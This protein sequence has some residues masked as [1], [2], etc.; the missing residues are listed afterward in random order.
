LA[1]HEG[2]VGGVKTLIEER[3][4]SKYVLRKAVSALKDTVDTVEL[5][6]WLRASGHLGASRPTKPSTGDVR[7]YRVQEVD[8]TKFIRLPVD[9]LEVCRGDSLTAEFFVG[10]IKVS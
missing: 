7:E 10:Q 5:E 6:G 1:F 3:G 4:V 8:G 2:G 9:H